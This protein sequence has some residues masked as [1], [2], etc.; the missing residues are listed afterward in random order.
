MV[1]CV[2]L[3]TDEHGQVQAQE[4]GLQYETAERGDHTTRTFSAKQVFYRS[5]TAPA[6]S[7]WHL[8]PTRQ[9][10][11]TLQGHLAFETET[12]QAFEL[13]RGDVLLTE[14]T[15][16]KGHRWR[17]LGDEPWVRVYVTLPESMDVSFLA[18]K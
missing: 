14:E 10:V 2:R 5:T 16:G 9:F 3:F 17:M 15:A 11:I 13:Q 18:N 8:D 12:G 1:R 6:S 7:D 4:G